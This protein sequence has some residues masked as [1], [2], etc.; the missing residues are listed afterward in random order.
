MKCLSI[1]QPFVELII[2]GKKT[3]EIRNWKTNYRGELLIHAS[4][5]PDKYALE[6]F[7]IDIETIKLGAILGKVKLIDCKDYKNDGDFLKDKNLHLAEDYK[8]G[9][10]FGFVLVEPVRFETPIPLK[11][12]LG[13]FDVKL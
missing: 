1:K 4:K 13:I 6:H 3:I 12:R 10:R 9:H 11:G 2:S 7:K 5:V 8:Q